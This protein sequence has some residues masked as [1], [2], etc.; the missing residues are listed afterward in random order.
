MKQSV[1][2]ECIVCGAKYY[3]CQS[4]NGNDETWKILY[5]TKNCQHIYDAMSGHLVGTRSDK[6][7]ADEL[8]KC[9]FTNI[10]LQPTMQKAYDE[11]MA[12]V[13][14]DKSK[15]ADTVKDA[16]KAKTVVEDEVKKEQVDKNGTNKNDSISTK[17]ENKKPVNFKNTSDFK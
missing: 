16:D 3:Y 2:R 14:A 15:E 7:C 17:V 13:N 4:C 8:A 11:I 1:E 6:E 12:S 9:D 5:D 10:K